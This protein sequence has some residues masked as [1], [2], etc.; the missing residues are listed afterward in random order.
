MAVLLFSKYN[1]HYIAVPFWENNFIHII[2]WGTL[3]LSI[4][5]ILTDSLTFFFTFYYFFPRSASECEMWIFSMIANCY[6]WYYHQ[7]FLLHYHCFSIIIAVYF[8]IW[9]RLVSSRSEYFE[10]R[11]R[12]YGDHLVSQVGWLVSC[13]YRFH[14]VH[15][16]WIASLS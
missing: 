8:K 11:V 16:R 5:G 2:D 10:Y 6:H 13:I 4:S 15:F 7:L 1:N 14:L 9:G 12:F 3:V